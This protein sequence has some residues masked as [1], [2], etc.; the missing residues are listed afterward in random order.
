[1][2]LLIKLL[3]GAG[4]YLASLS[5]R[6]RLRIAVLGVVV[7]MGSGIYKLVNSINRLSAKPAKATPEQLIEPVQKLYSQ[8]KAGATDY[9]YHRKVTTAQMDSLSRLI[10]KS[11]RP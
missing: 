4:Q 3:S 6:T 7:L 9:Y 5:D 11:K 2:K 1:M 8:T 10:E